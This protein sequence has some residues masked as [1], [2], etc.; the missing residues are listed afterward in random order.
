MAFAG[1]K[2]Q[3][4]KANQ[5]VNEKIGG[6]E[7]TKLDT[8]FVDMERRT[9]V[10]NEL[11]DGLITK[12]KEYLQPNP[13]SRAKLMVSKLR[14][15]GKTPAYPQ[16]EG[17]LGE[18][19]VKYGSDLGEESVYA[20]SLV[21]TGEAMKQLA[22]IKFSLEDNIKQTFLEPLHHLQTKDLKEVMHHL[23][24]LEGRRLDY[25]CKKRKQAKGAHISDDE[26]KLSEDKF[27]ESLS[28]AQMGM[29]NLLEDDVVQ[30]SQLTTFAE[31]LYEY[32]KQ[33][34]EVM[35]SLSE[36]LAE[37]KEEAKGRP[38]I[39]FEPKKLKEL[40]LPVIHSDDTDYNGAPPPYSASPR[41]SPLPSPVRSPARTPL[42]PQLPS[43]RALYDFEPENEGELGFKEGDLIILTNRIDDNWYEGNVNGKSGF[44]PVTYVEIVTPLP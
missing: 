37:K 8:D 39:D 11:V 2:K 38:R 20:I 22:D 28:L 3:I 34:A 7:G 9:V 25:D 18:T 41:G 6:A 24:K 36:V 31:S 33:C 21:E 14:G 10:I 35:Q 42:Q 27:E 16:P 43:C 26:L 17:T 19:M 23:K 30:I 1:L 13:T 5:Y 12:T 44:F 29:N 4:N 15:S 40:N 32:H